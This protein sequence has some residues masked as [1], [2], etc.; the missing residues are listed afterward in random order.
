MP[1][2]RSTRAEVVALTARRD[3]LASRSETVAAPNR[4]QVSLGARWDVARPNE[5]YL[6]L[7][8]E[9][10]TSWSVGLFAGWR[11]FDGD[12]KAS[13]RV[14]LVMMVGMIA[15]SLLSLWLLA[16]PMYMRT[17]DI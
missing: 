7:E 17:A 11:V 16:Q 14:H 2:G 15:M 5:R 4:P 3:A 8:D 13:F 1:P 12:R 9:W 10:N 6:P